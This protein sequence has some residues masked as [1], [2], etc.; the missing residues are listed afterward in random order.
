ME[1][2]IARAPD[3]AAMPRAPRTTQDQGRRAGVLRTA[4]TLPPRLAGAHA[5]LAPPMLAALAASR[6]A[7]RGARPARVAL[8][9]A[10]QARAVP[11]AVV[12]ALRRDCEDGNGRVVGA[13]APTRA[14][15]TAAYAAVTR[16]MAGARLARGR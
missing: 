11:V 10:M 1:I 3:A 14:R 8:A 5:P 4:G 6:L 12:W 13:V 9:R 16:A 2:T 15:L 7:A